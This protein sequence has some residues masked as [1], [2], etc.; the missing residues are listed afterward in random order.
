LRGTA[1][2]DGGGVWNDIDGTMTVTDSAFCNNSPRHILGLVALSQ[3]Q[4]T[5][6]CPIPVCPGDINGDG[7]VGINDFLAVLT[8]WGACT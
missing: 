1:L 3:V 2:A 4:M 8:A 5:T 7:I 6:F